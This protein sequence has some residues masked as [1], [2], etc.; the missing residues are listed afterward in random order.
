MQAL[1]HAPF[2][3]ILQRY[4]TLNFNLAETMSS[5]CACTINAT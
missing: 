1:H 2:C 4:H 3:K 5:I